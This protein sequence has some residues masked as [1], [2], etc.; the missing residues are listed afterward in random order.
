MYLVILCSFYSVWYPVVSY[1]SYRIVPNHFAMHHTVSYC[2]ISYQHCIVSWQHIATHRISPCIR[3]SRIEPLCSLVYRTRR[4]MEASRG[5]VLLLYHQQWKSKTQEPPSAAREVVK[6]SRNP[7]RS[8][9]TTVF[10]TNYFHK[11]TRLKLTV[12]GAV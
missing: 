7:E 3:A 6:P 11:I 2:F 1:Q 4:L 10:C 12:Y 8:P 5:C 9:S